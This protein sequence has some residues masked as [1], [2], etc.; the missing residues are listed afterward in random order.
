MSHSTTTKGLNKAVNNTE[1]ID[2]AA[3]EVAQGTK[4]NAGEV[5]AD[6]KKAFVNIGGHGKVVVT[7]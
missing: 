3:N 5:H 4:R 2:I 1:G 7:E 6:Y